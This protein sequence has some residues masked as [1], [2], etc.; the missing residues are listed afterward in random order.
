[1]M[2]NFR[3]V[4]EPL[5]RAEKVLRWALG[6]RP[7]V[8][9]AELATPLLLKRAHS[10][11]GVRVELGTHPSSG[12][13]AALTRILKGRDWRVL[14]SENH[15]APHSFAGNRGAY[16]LRLCDGNSLTVELR[17][18]HSLEYEAEKMRALPQLEPGTWSFDFSDEAA[19][20]QPEALL[21]A[22]T[23]AHLETAGTQPATGG[24]AIAAL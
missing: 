14:A 22:E 10:S 6:Q 15:G 8:A 11:P 13:A 3:V 20:S 7:C 12:V 4:G 23:A 9:H 18:P 17:L 24:G 16:H 21:I 1:M 5:P 19:L 2:R